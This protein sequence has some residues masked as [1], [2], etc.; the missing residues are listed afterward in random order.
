MLKTKFKAACFI[1]E[2]S[3]P[4]SELPS[5]KFADA[6]VRRGPGSLLWPS[7]NSGGPPWL[8]NNIPVPGTK[9]QFS[10]VHYAFTVGTRN[11]TIKYPVL[12]ALSFFRNVTDSTTDQ[13]LRKLLYDC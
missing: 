2:A 12:K 13:R 1:V 7:Y 5:S 11:K 10:V 8:R 3:L 4:S 9:L 6:E